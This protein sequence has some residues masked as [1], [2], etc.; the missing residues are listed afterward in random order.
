MHGLRRRLRAKQPI[1]QGLASLSAAIEKSVARVSARRANL[2]DLQINLELP[3]N[4]HREAIK[5]AIIDHQVVI[6]CGETGSGKTTQLPQICLELGYG[7]RGFIGHT[8]P[9]RIAAR[10]IANRVAEEIKSNAGQLVGYKV[11]FSDRTSDSTLIKLMTDGILLA[12]TQGDRWLNQYEVIIVDEAHERSLNIDFLLGYLHRLL[13]K[14]PDLKVIIT[15]ATI[16]P[17]RFSHHFNDAPIV[18]V[19]GRSYPVEV[20]Y[21]PLLGEDEDDRD[22]DLQQ[23]ILD[24]VDEVSGIDRGDILIFLSGEREIR[25]TNESLRKHKLPN[26]EIL[27]LYARLSASQQQRVFQGTSKRRI[28]LATNVAETS[29][30][31]PGIRYVIDSGTARISRYSH[32][33]KIQ[34]LPIEPISQASAAQRAGRCGRV[35]SGICIRLYSEEDF[36]NRPEFTDAEILRTNLAAVILQMCAL[37]LGEI[38]DFPFVDPPDRRLISDGF[39]LLF[40]LQAVDDKRRISELG[41][42]LAKL[43]IDPRL[44]RMILAARDFASLRE[45]LIIVSALAIQDPR[46]RPLEQQQ[47]ADEKH[48]RF[49]DDKSDFQALLSLWNYYHEQARHLSTNKLRKLC[50]DEFLSFVRMREWHDLQREL[51]ALVTTMGMRPNQEEADYNAVHQALLSGLLTHIGF[52]HEEQQWLGVRSRK[53][54]VFPGSGLFKKAPKWLMAAELVETSRLYAR[55]IARIDPAWI[56]KLAPHLVKR[57][58][59]EPHWEKRAG[60]VVA[61][62]RVLLYGLP[63]IVGRKVN[64][65]PIDPSFSREIFIRDALVGQDFYSKAPFYQHNKQLLAEIVQLEAK[66]RRRDLLADEEVLFQFYDELIP[67]NIHNTPRFERWRKQAEKNNPKLLFFDRNNLINQELPQDTVEQF[68]DVLNI[69]GLELPLSYTFDPAAEDDGITVTLPLAAL[70]QINPHRLEWVI[71]GLL[72]ER[73]TALLKSLPKQLRKH[74]VPVPNYVETLIDCLQPSDKPLITAISQELQRITGIEIPNNSWHPDNL[75]KYL[76][77]R[78]KVI[79]HEGKILASGR[80][81]AT[82]QKR[83]KDSAEQSFAKLPTAELEKTSLTDWDFGNLP[84][85]VEIKRNGVAFKGYPAIVVEGS[86]IALRVLDNRAKARQAHHQGVRAL[87]A[88]KLRDKIKYIKRMLSDQR[89]M[90][91]HYIGIGSLHELHNDLIEASLNRALFA[92][93]TIPRSREEFDVCLV[94]GRSQLI[95]VAEEYRSLVSDI[96]ANHHAV[97]KLL[98][99]SIPLSWYEAVKD[100]QE[101]LE[102]LIY[103]G[104]ISQTPFQW[105]QHLPRYL[106]AIALR[107]DK[108]QYA[109]DKDRQRL[110]D[111]ARLW[112]DCQRRTESN[113]QR[114]INDPELEK[115]RWMLEELR[116]SQFAQE[117]KTAMPVSVKRL[118]AQWKKVA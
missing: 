53:F 50:R 72:A 82:L 80:D 68:P 107:M 85:E 15:S 64:Y 48:R 59:S 47:A 27:P 12:E 32:R 116:V 36:N 62:E 69:N 58:Y 117:L 88:N 100:I 102:Q 86:Q 1:D 79:D 39:K 2:P 110:S 25:E 31:V 40:E 66:G 5:Q 23:A 87:L 4:Q 61:K 63:V 46:E 93:T 60:R 3:I 11:R 34:R 90:S 57:N 70:N 104:F 105:L 29:L 35:S 20:L 17:E 99:G 71:P 84:S 95:P 43:P 16:D 97:R 30:T 113:Q 41:T 52:R 38:E 67:Q 42:Q 101:Q 33:S 76:F 118:E 112:Q 73:M 114:N 75:P 106:K 24:A 19:S 91:L 115:F 21:R 45:V 81:L 74:F 109:P 7:C 103:P 44:G 89:D 83:F 13:P 6:I 22:R 54:F 56:E 26:T 111:I 9:R 49:R 77:M 51:H 14:R 98:N 10:A 37:R 92:D 78:I 18:E 55:T 65:G 94:N 96:L 8:Q 108:L 28:V